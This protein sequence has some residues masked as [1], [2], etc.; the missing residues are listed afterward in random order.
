M[1]CFQ[2]T[3]TQLNPRTGQGL[4]MKKILGFLWLSTLAVTALA[5]WARAQ[6]QGGPFSVFWDF[7]T[8]SQATDL[9]PIIASGGVFTSS[10][11]SFFSSAT[12]L[13]ANTTNGR[14]G[15]GNSAVVTA[16]QSYS[17]GPYFAWTLTSSPT[18]PQIVLNITNISF[19]SRSAN[20]GPQSWRL[21]AVY[22]GT[23]QTIAKQL[24]VL[25]NDTLWTP[26]IN[27]TTNITLTTS[28][29]VMFRLYGLDGVG[30]AV[31][32][33]WRI[34]DLLLAGTA[35]SSLS[36]SSVTHDTAVLNWAPDINATGYEIEVCKTNS[37]ININ[38]D[39]VIIT[40]IFY[41]DADNKAIELT[42]VGNMQADLTQY[43][44]SRNTGGTSATN[45]T[46]ALSGSL[47]SVNG[48]TKMLQPGETFR[49]LYVRASSSYPVD[50]YLTT[51][52]HFTTGNLIC[53]FSTDNWLGLYKSANLNPVDS[54]RTPNPESN[55]N[56]RL[57]GIS[58]GK[59]LVDP[60]E[61]HQYSFADA[62]ARTPHY[63]YVP[64]FSNILTPNAA[65][66]H[67]LINLRPR[68]NYFV[69][70]RGVSNFTTGDW[71]PY[72]SFTTLPPPP[73]M[74]IMVR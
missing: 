65:T 47:T 2:T 13:T 44:L 20:T 4:F 25:P 8:G 61:W 39:R 53:N 40:K 63:V 57:P 9:K 66:T 3:H 36:V 42:N 12:T 50:A 38:T 70:V 55:I 69:R 64:A 72:V 23:V 35:M 5:P 21:D 10:P 59:S 18:I 46:F 11:L 30:T 19:Y 56:T 28:S 48:A 51:G 43:S 22:G 32:N 26:R 73:G 71:T 68:S 60:K 41:G 24:N 52:P 37:F 33:N 27:V 1:A 49:L 15:G 45:T 16:N 58:Q 6:T 34:D 17:G 29:P 54:A 14:P 31:Q 67:T 7:D 74:V 62:K